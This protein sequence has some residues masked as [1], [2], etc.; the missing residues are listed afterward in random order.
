MLS[1]QEARER[2]KLKSDAELGISPPS[3]CVRRHRDRLVSE[4]GAW[5]PTVM[6]TQG[7]VGA[8]PIAR[9]AATGVHPPL[10]PQSEYLE[11]APDPEMLSAFQALQQAKARIKVV[12]PSPSATVS[13]TKS[14][15]LPAAAGDSTRKVSSSAPATKAQKTPEASAKKRYVLCYVRSH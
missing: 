7:A 15:S 13:T 6:T 1:R 11:R 8:T 5:D 9:H 4:D 12:Q 10:R 14:T 2:A 3:A